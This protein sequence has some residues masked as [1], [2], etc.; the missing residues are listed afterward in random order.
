M[1]R[2]FAL[3]CAM[4]WSVSAAF[5]QFQQQTAADGPT[6]GQSQTLRWQAGMVVTAVG[7]A[8]TRLVGTVPVPVDW[9]EQQVRV[10]SEDIS[11]GAKVTYRM[12]EGGVRQMVVQVPYLPG[13]EQCR[14]VVT[15][16]VT[17][18]AVLPPSETD[19]YE[20]P[21][22]RRMPP[23]VRRHLAPS[24]LIESQSPRIR[25]LA[26]EITAEKQTAW[27]KVEAIYDWVREHVEYRNGPL[28]G[29]LAALNDGTGDCEEMTSLFIALCRAMDVPA[30]TVWVPGHCYPEFYLVDKEGKGHWFPCQAAGSR[31]FGGIPEN[32]PIL[33]KGDN[34]RSPSNPR[35]R[36]RYLPEELSGDSVGGRPR[37]EWIRQL[38]PG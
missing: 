18:N 2:W 16:E 15:F 35:E 7:G 29:A 25:S 19:I 3:S 26:R 12:V 36:K 20:L 23:D 1:L 10:V 14:V 13:G 17:R 22:K 33:Q 38:Q 9:P 21:D 4:F 8:C 28:K 11:P 37:V 5:G 24:P 34:F 31:A 30:R 27:A 6:L 32:R